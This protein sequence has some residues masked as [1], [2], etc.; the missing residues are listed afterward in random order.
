M[1]EAWAHGVSWTRTLGG[2]RELH[3]CRLTPLW[4]LSNPGLRELPAE[5]GQLSNLWQLDIED[6]HISNV[7]ADIR[8]EGRVPAAP[9][10]WDR[11]SGP[12]AGFW[13]WE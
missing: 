8:K 2:W 4:V 1:L 7:P 10:G 13:G 9:C 3:T 11:D 12:P 5:L 6:L